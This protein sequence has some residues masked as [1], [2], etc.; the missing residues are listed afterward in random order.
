MNECTIGIFG[1]FF[2]FCKCWKGKYGMVLRKHGFRSCYQCL[3]AILIQR[4]CFR[5]E[6]ILF[7][8][9]SPIP[10]RMIS[11]LVEVVS[12]AFTACTPSFTLSVLQL[13]TSASSIV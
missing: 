4:A 13:K 5:V 6:F 12:R 2:V 10:L 11:H 8:P 7:L 3:S 1:G 9:H